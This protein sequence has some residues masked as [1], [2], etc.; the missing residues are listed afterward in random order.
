MDYGSM[1]VPGAFEFGSYPS[2]GASSGL[3]RWSL[4]TEAPGGG[5]QCIRA[6]LWWLDV[7]LLIYPPKGADYS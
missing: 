3:E 4:G 5:S 2:A 7:F 6:A 1:M